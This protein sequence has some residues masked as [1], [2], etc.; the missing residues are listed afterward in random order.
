MYVLFM[1]RI[2]VSFI[3]PVSLINFLIS[4][5]NLFS[6][7]QTPGLGYQ[8]CGS[9]HSLL[10]REDPYNYNPSSFCV[11]SQEHRSVTWSLLFS[12]YLILYGSFLL[13]WLCKSLSANPELFFSE[14]C[15]TCKLIFWYICVC[16]G[17]NSVSSHST[18][19]LSSPTCILLWKN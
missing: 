2:S 15:S 18:I 17:V 8:I 19:F 5:E 13:P 7:W 11:P 1:S 10:S 6:Q 3:H 4:S 9:N 14:N 16:V 12:S